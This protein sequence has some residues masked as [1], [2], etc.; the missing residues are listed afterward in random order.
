VEVW[1]DDYGWIEFDPTS[2][3]MAPG[4]DYPFQFI[5]PQQWLPLVEEVLSRSGEIDVAL[6]AEEE[7]AP[8]SWWRVLGRQVVRRSWILPVLLALLIIAVYLPHRIL[9]Y[10]RMVAA[11]RSDDP[12]RPVLIRWRRFSAALVRSGGSISRNETVTEWANRMEAE[13]LTGFRDWTDLYL[14][15]V[16]SPEFN[17]GDLKRALEKENAVG[18]RFRDL[19]WIRRLSSALKPGRRLPW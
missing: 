3:T 12:R 4:E 11:G 1:L 6:A 2:Q 13:G 19:P 8:E 15:A 7:T 16:Y 14:K 5:N 9:P 18:R 17:G 10:L